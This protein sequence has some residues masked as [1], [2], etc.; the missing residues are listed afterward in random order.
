VVLDRTNCLFRAREHIEMAR[1]LRSSACKLRTSQAQAKLTQ[2]A[3]LYEQLSLCYLEESCVAPG[4]RRTDIRTSTLED[5]ATEPAHRTL[6]TAAGG[7][8]DHRH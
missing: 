5:V 3:S 8:S 7:R 4:N 6:R 1:R 2:L